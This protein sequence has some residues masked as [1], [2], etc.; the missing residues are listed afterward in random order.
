MGDS[1]VAAT[2]TIREDGTVGAIGALVQKAVA[3]RESGARIFLVPEG[4]SPDDIADAK[5]AAG[6]SVRI[7]SVSTLDDALAELAKLGGKPLPA[8]SL[9]SGT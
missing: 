3:V 2:G 8:S 9:Q 1:R 4:Q 7:I 5:K 6:S